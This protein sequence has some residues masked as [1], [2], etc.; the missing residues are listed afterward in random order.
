MTLHGLISSFRDIMLKR[1]K[2]VRAIQRT[3]TR[4][5]TNMKMNKI[6]PLEKSITTK[7]TD[8]N[9]LESPIKV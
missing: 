1:W 8:S 3:S 6:K 4:N 7:M 5:G 2:H 9:K